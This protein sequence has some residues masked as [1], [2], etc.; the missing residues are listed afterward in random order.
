MRKVENRGNY[1][2]SAIKGD[3]YFQAIV[4]DKVLPYAAETYDIAYLI[5][6]GY[7]YHG[8]INNN[9]VTYACRMLKIDS[10]GS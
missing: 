1:H 3:V 2:M 4:D 5:G 9:F 6:L 10:I 8:N 7:K